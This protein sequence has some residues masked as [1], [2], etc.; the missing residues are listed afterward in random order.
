M[1]CSV[2][3]CMV[4]DLLTEYAYLGELAGLFYTLKPTKNGFEFN[5]RGYSTHQEEFLRNVLEVFYG[6]KTQFT[7]DRFEQVHDIQRKGM[8]SSDAE[9]LKSQIKY[10]LNFILCP[11]TFHR[12]RYVQVSLINTTQ[13]VACK[14]M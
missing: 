6:N 13:F 12:S 7:R 3:A 8:E 4:K 9:P 2:L 14:A 5:V 10:L 11:K 1:H